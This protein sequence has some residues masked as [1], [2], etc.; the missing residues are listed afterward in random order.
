MNPL[1]VSLRVLLSS[2]ALFAALAPSPAAAQPAAVT[3]AFQVNTY[4]DGDQIFPVVAAND[5]GR[6]VVVWHST[7]IYEARPTQD[8]DGYGLFGQ[9]FDASGERIG[10]EFRVHQT[11]PG[12]RTSRT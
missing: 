11:T 8:G 10:T 2:L 12:N 1:R 4:T 5:S 3:P 6:F 9:V 7:W